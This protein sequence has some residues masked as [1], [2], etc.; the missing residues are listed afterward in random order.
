MDAAE[1]AADEGRV[2][3]VCEVG[4]GC[5]PWGGDGFGGVGLVSG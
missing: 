1:D 4:G 5:E 3:Q 2:G